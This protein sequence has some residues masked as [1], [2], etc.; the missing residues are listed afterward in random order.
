MYARFGYTE[1]RAGEGNQFFDLNGIRPGQDI[2]LTE[3]G[4]GI[5]SQQHSCNQVV[6]IN[7]V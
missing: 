2:G 4:L 6:N 1:Q 3:G 7:Q 5:G